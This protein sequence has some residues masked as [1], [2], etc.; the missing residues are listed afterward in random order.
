MYVFVLL[1]DVGKTNEG[2]HSLEIN[3]ETYVL[4][5][6]N[7]D[8][9]IRYSGLLHAQDFPCPSVEKLDRSEIEEFCLTSGYSPKFVE[10]GF[11]PKTDE[12]RLLLAPPELNKDTSEWEKYPDEDESINIESSND[13]NSSEL[14]QIRKSLEDLL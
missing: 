8:D 6:E 3:G 5:F 11:V 9:A 10:N 14:D 13:N 2:V 4:M 7:E 12:E 1:Y